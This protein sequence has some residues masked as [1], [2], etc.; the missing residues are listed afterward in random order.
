VAEPESDGDR[1][2]EQLRFLNVVCLAMVA[3]VFAFGVVAWFLT[4][5]GNALAGPQL[6]GWVGWVGAAVAIAL[7]VAAPVVQR[8]NLE[9]TARG[10]RPEEQAI[11]ALES[12]RLGTLLGFLLRD[13]AA[14]VGLMLTVVTGE[15][16][17]T[18]GL[19]AVTVVAMFW[20]WPR[21][22]ELDELLGRQ[23]LASAG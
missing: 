4:R 7:L 5:D 10:Q 8:K 3:S 6:P 21:R 2:A 9:S 13:G 23:G 19:G 14:I 11:G 18:Y 1:V 17:W 20:A 22:E 16:M 12:Y 15:P